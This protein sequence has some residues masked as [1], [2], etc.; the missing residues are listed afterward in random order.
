[1]LLICDRSHA[2]RGHASRDA[3]RHFPR[4]ECASSAG[5]G[6]SGAALPRGAWERSVNL[7]H[8]ALLVGPALAGKP[9]ICS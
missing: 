8:M 6:A 2:P 5:R 4:P 9:L 1:M 7:L 3:P